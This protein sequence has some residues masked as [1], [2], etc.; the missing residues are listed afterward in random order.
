MTTQDYHDNIGNVNNFQKPNI[1]A[2]AQARTQ[3]SEYCHK[4]QIANVPCVRVWLAASRC[5]NPISKAPQCLYTY[6]IC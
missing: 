2:L 6:V 5:C 4:T 3:Y 1:H